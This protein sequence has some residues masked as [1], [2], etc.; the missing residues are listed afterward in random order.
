MGVRLHLLLLVPVVAT[1]AGCEREPSRGSRPL[2]LAAS[3][4]LPDRFAFGRDATPEEIA[5]VDVDVMA[6]GHGLP[7]GRG[8]SGQG[9]EV[10][11]TSC[12]GCHGAQGEGTGAG[13]A[14]VGRNAGD[15][16]DF[17][18]SLEKERAKTIG[19]YWPYAPTLFDYIRRAMPMDRPGSLTDDEVYAVTAYLLH[20]NEV[21][22]EDAVMDARTLPQVR[23]PA[24]ARFVPDDRE[25]ST[26]VR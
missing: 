3:E 23:M 7:P 2:A 1:T 14:L 15:V 19:N 26:R 16:F 18:V 20:R 13:S 4:R 11:A 5:L 10:Y 9:A 25:Q 12:A 22:A 24:R 8:N 21:I 17:A 6:D